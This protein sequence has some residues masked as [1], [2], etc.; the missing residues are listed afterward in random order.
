MTNF[1]VN[2]ERRR[3]NSIKWD[4]YKGRDVLP[5]WLADMDFLCPEPIIA[6]LQQRIAHGI[7]GYTSP[8]DDLYDA[9]LMML[10]RDYRWKVDPAWLVWM[11]GIVTGINA[12]CRCLA[13]KDEEI[14]TF[15]PVYNPFLEAPL[16]VERKLL[17]V[18]MVL[19]HGRYVMD[20]D[21]LERRITPRTRLLELCSPHNP[22]GRVFSR[23]ELT[24]L[25]EICLKHDLYI[26]S[27]EIHCGLVIEEGVQHIPIGALCPEIAQRSVTMMAPSKTFNIPGLCCSFAVIPNRDLRLRMQDTMKGLVPF[28]NLLGYTAAIAAYRDCDEWHRDLLR[29]LRQ[30]RDLLEQTVAR[31]PGIS[32]THVEATY[33][34]WVD[35]RNLGLEFPARYL[36]EQGLGVNDGRDFGKPGFVRINFACPRTQVEKGLAI[37]ENSIAKLNR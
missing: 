8:P 23:E 3:T 27:D 37:L 6:A 19:D 21:E 12:A 30:N 1:D 26:S 18:E 14:V 2:V 17:K 24:R 10:E 25:A 7:F 32:M 22:I 9:V 4:R 5:M 34:G 33:L 15:Y 16:S 28:V 11:P 20:L 36:E 35:M 31:I 13:A 29:Y